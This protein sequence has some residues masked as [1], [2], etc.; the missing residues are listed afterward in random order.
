MKSNMKFKNLILLISI[1]IFLNGCYIIKQGYFLFKHIHRAADIEKIAENDTT[2]D[3]LK[4]FLSLVKDMKLFTTTHIGLNDD[5]NYTKFVPVNKTYLIDL[6]CA[7]KKYSFEQYVWKYPF[8]GSFPYRGFYKRTEALRQAEKLKSKGYDVI[9]RKAGAFST[10]GFFDDPIYS[11]MAE[12]PAYSLASLII[13]EQTHSTIFLKNH[14]EFNEELATFIGE[15]GALQYIKYKYGKDSEIYRNSLNIQ[16]D[17]GVFISRLKQ[18]QVSLQTLYDSHKYIEEKAVQKENI[19]KEF[20]KALV[21]DYDK[22]F[23]TKIYKNIE[24]ANINNAYITSFMT[25]NRDLSP[26]YKLYKKNAF[27]LTKTVEQLKKIKGIKED[28]KKY[29][30]RLISGT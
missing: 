5:N 30:E 16:H 22:I 6:L 24:Q 15:T 9:I 10:L 12:L 29:L 28:P 14:T 13:H 27:N 26:F 20:K 2:S 23:K 11:F 25:Y 18:L 7:S 21:L 8:F 19:I 1:S 3:E 17:K 4:D